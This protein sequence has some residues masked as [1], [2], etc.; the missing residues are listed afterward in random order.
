MYGKTQES[1]SHNNLY[2]NSTTS[3]VLV[4]DFRTKTLQTTDVQEAK[5]SEVEAPLALL[6]I[7]QEA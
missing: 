4:Y 5:G 7:Q 6:Q 2:V 1:L 3:H